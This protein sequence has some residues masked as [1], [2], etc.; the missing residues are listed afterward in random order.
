MQTSTNIRYIILR[1]FNETVVGLTCTAN[2]E[3]GS[4]RS[5]SSS[6]KGR[7]LGRS[8]AGAV[9]SITSITERIGESNHREQRQN[10]KQNNIFNVTTSDQEATLHKRQ[11]VTSLG[12]M[13]F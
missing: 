8:V 5:G 12:Q 2:A 9:Q 4:A 3:S 11:P 6:T 10:Y 7:A 1:K 13:R